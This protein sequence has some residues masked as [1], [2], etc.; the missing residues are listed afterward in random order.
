MPTWT[1]RPSRCTRGPC[2]WGTWQHAAGDLGRDKAD[3]ERLSEN[4]RAYV[5]RFVAGF[6]SAEENAARLFG[7]WAMAAPSR[8]IQAFFSTRVLGSASTRSVSAGIWTRSW[9]TGRSS[10]PW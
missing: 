9:A 6:Y 7:P 2:V 1:S 3:E 8:W 10:P 4:F 5:E